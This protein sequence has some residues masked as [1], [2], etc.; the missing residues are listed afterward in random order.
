MQNT[1]ISLKSKDLPIPPNGKEGWPWKELDD[2]YIEEI[3]DNS[4]YPCISIIIPSYNY[5]QFIEETIRSILL[6]SYQNV[7]CIV[8]DGGSTDDTVNI[9]Q[10]YDKYIT[11]WIS[12]TDKG[13]TDAINKG[14]S[15]CTGDIFVWLNADDLYYSSSTLSTVAKLYL[16]GYDF[17]VGDCFNIDKHGEYIFFADDGK[18]IPTN[19]RKSLRYWS[20]GF[21]QQPAVFVAKKLTDNC[22]P[23]D[24][25]LYFAMDIQFF[26]R[27]LH[28]DPKSIWIKENLVRFRCHESS[29]TR[30]FNPSLYSQEL[31]E[32]PE[33]H[34]IVINE[35]SNLS[36]SWEI[37]F[38]RI[39]ANDYL[40]FQKLL[41]KYDNSLS[42]HQV[43]DSL[44]YRPLLISRVLFWKVLVKAVIGKG[45][46]SLLRKSFNK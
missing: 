2:I 16:S 45:S 35:S 27:V 20:S 36:N 33:I 38:F 19:F 5:G 34:K 29:K 28:Q 17:I 22:F 44:I 31:E 30:S 13:Q 37:F 43:L 32:E 39:E 4:K 1:K 15:H 9:L 41:N 23:L 26:L 3:L 18:S 12:E 40:Y 14:Y 11:Y 21:L 6:Q 10:K 7:E 46:Y 8:I 42:M 25:T 24:N